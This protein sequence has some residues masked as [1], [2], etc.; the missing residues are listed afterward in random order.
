MK[1]KRSI[2]TPIPY[3][4]PE[5]MAKFPGRPLVRHLPIPFVALLAISYFGT[6]SGQRP[7]ASL[8]PCPGLT[9]PRTIQHNGRTALEVQTRMEVD[10]DGAP[11][12]YGPKGKKTLDILAHAYSP[13]VPGK[14]RELVGYMTDDDEGKK[15]TIQGKDDP[16]PG[17]Y[18]SQTDYADIHNQR[19]ED[20]RRYVNATTINYVVLGRAA[21]N[22]GVQLGDFV[23]AYS[24]RTGKSAYA[25]VG[26]SGNESG[27]EGSLALVRNLGYEHITNGIDES[28]EDPEIVIRYFPH[29][30]PKQQFFKTQA[31]LDEAAKKLGLTK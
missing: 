27:A 16:Y 13:K 10:V 2:Q 21:I 6:A 17:Y 18:V 4:Y 24:C 20:P 15:P 30:N 12:A 26:D 5:V 14:P 23:T 22:A 11:N 8:R 25:I 1:G 7:E 19:M 31:E 28:V 29:T 9:Q 3:V